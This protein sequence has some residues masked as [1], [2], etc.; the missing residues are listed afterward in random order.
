LNV[1]NRD[2]FERLQAHQAD[3]CID[4]QFACLKG[5]SCK[6]LNYTQ[7]ARCTDGFCTIEKIRPGSTRPGPSRR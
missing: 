4:G 6:P 5:V 3:I 2:Y 1:Y 7:E